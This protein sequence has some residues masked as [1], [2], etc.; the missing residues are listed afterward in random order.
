MNIDW[1]FIFEIQLIFEMR[2]FLFSDA[3]FFWSSS[4]DAQF[5]NGFPFGK[6]T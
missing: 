5:N 2:Y 4:S 6:I 3:L 1:F